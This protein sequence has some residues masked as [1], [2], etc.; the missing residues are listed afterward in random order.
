MRH[1][2]HQAITFT[3][4]QSLNEIVMLAP[5]TLPV[6]QAM[7]LDTCCGGGLPLGEVARRHGLDPEQVIQVLQD[8][9]PHP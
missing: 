7:G 4:T 2:V 3:L 8:E 9:V 1:K 6:L 5:Q